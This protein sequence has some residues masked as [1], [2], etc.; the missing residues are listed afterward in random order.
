MAFAQDFV[1]FVIGSTTLGFFT[2]APYLLPTYESKRV[3]VDRLGRT[4]ATLAVGVM[5]GILAA[6]TGGS[7]IAEHF[8][9]AYGLLHCSG[10]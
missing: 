8:G 1:L 9:L 10:G 5:A 4:T 2:I 6:R 3:S 7:V